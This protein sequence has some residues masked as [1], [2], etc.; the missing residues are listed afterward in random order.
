MTFSELGGHSSWLENILARVK[1]TCNE[2]QQAPLM[3]KDIR[4]LTQSNKDLR[5][6]NH[7]DIRVV[8]T[9]KENGGILAAMMNLAH[10]QTLT[11]KHSTSLHRQDIYTCIRKVVSK[12]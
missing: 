12:R 4:R 7:L 2:D 1:K 5:I 8:D 6:S 3:K 10:L 9:T 11:R